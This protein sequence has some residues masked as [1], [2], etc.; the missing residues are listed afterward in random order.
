M[1]LAASSSTTRRRPPFLTQQA[2]ST[3]IRRLE[4]DVGVRPFVRGPRSTS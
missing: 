2:V 1:G 3:T 4:R